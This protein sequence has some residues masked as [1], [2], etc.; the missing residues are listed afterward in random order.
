M[1]CVLISSD[2]GLEDG[3]DLQDIEVLS[4]RSRKETIGSFIGSFLSRTT[5]YS[6]KSLGEITAGTT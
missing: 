2:S 3:M 1:D 5:T 6:R 4:L